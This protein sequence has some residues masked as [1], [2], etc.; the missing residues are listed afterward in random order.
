MRRLI[1]P[2]VFLLAGCATVTPAAPAT[3]PPPPTLVASREAEG[4][5]CVS[6]QECRSLLTVRSDG[7]WVLE[8]AEDRTGTLDPDQLT[9]LQDAAARTTLASAPPFTGTCPI[10]W[11]GQ[12][13]TYIWTSGDQR[14]TV[15]SCDREVDLA[16]PLVA[17][18]EE[19]A[20]DLG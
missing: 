9:R 2:A 5:L 11:D 7:T 6:G 4:G 19:L 10:A 14:H 16:D 1:V 17:T 12:E 3:S 20:G 15:A 8:G 13:Y 18:L